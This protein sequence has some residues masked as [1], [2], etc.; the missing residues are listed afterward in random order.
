ME[1]KRSKYELQ[2]NDLSEEIKRYK[3]STLSQNAQIADLQ[4]ALVK[5]RDIEDQLRMSREHE[6]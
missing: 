4:N 6:E 5:F 1:F 2:I 3:T